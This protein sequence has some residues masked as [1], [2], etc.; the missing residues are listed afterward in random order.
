MGN[1]N[2]AFDITTIA[3]LYE[4]AALAA[5]Q[6]QAAKAAA[7]KEASKQGKGIWGAG[8]QAV[9]VAHD[10]GHN[11]ATMLTLF[12]IALAA[13]DVPEGTFKG[14][15]AD[16]AKLREEVQTGKHPLTGEET[17]FG[18]KDAMIISRADARKRYKVITPEEA[19]RAALAD[20][21][22]EWDADSLQALVAY[23][24]SMTGD[25]DGEEQPVQVEERQAQAA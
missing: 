20:L 21:T 9:K 2:Q 1:N 17:G 4:N 5:A 7:S 22:K 10:N 16:L 19:A 13:A 12:S 15:Q 24:R 25:S 14:Y 11:A 18:I 8:L 6:A 3:A 23:A